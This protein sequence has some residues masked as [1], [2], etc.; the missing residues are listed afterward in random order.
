VKGFRQFLLR[1]NVVDLAVA[2]VVGTAFTAVVS[3]LVAGL[4]TPLIAAIIGK[5]DFS[6]LQ[7]TLHHSTFRYG[8]VVNA[9]ITFL[10]IA[11]VVYFAVVLPINKLMTR[12]SKGAPPDTPTK[13]CPECLSSI[14]AAARKC[15]FCTS[16][17]PAIAP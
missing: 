11:T 7:F 12:F 9:V 17:Q 14:P 15:A 2:V 3:A 6:Q 13:D 8:L 10:A 1:G 16:V 5:P 4:L